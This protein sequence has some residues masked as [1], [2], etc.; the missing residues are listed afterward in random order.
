MCTVL[1]D[2][3][4]VKGWEACRCRAFQATDRTEDVRHT[5][6]AGAPL[7]LIP[8]IGDG[9]Q[10]AYH[11]MGRCGLWWT[12]TMSRRGRSEPGR[13]LSPWISG[14]GFVRK[15]EGRS[16]CQGCA[17]S[18][19]RNFL[20]HDRHVST[21]CFSVWKVVEEFCGAVIRMN[22]SSLSHQ[23]LSWMNSCPACL[24]DFHRAVL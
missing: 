3:R 9:W 11:G 7:V 21:N 4:N 24:P 10:A 18:F 8:S 1:V 22:N 17:R 15:T 5:S 12:R 2:V 14:R 20:D 19:P 6:W 23:M 13:D 16:D